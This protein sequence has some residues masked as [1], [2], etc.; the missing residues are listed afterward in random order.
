[1]S[2]HPRCK[3]LA[4]TCIHGRQVIEGR[5]GNLLAY[6]SALRTYMAPVISQ[7]PTNK[8]R[9]ILEKPKDKTPM[10]QQLGVVNQLKCDSCDKIYITV[11]WGNRQKPGDKI[12]RTHHRWTP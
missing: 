8:L 1:M 6:V 2:P 5:S 4:A 7:K 11:H 3:I 9:E 12:Q 10:E